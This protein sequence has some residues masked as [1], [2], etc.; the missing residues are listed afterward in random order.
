[1]ERNYLLIGIATT[2]S[3]AFLLLLFLFSLLRFLQ[4]RTK[5]AESLTKMFG[6]LLLSII[7]YSTCSFISYFDPWGYPYQVQVMIFVFVFIFQVLGYYYFWRLSKEIWD[8]KE[9][10]KRE[11]ILVQIIAL[12]III[13][14]L[15]GAIYGWGHIPFGENNN[16]LI[17]ESYII[18]TVYQLLILFKAIGSS[19][20][21]YKKMKKQISEIPAGEAKIE[22]K[23][24][25]F[26]VI[27]INIFFFGI[28]IFNI[29]TLLVDAIIKN[30]IIYLTTLFLL[31]LFCFI[32]FNG[33][34]LPDWFKENLLRIASKV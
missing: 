20:R 22:M 15:L 32:G 5:I 24:H 21:L 10:T 9:I 28:L 30:E 4:R 7:F 33:L 18:I 25:Y 16:D 11:N 17:I 1:M 6:L 31:P 3:A 12:L 19:M 29:I 2:I 26:A 34:F 8:Q 23:I 14:L 13:Y 27:N